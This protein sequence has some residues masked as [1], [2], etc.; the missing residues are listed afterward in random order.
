MIVNKV[1]I[2][3]IKIIYKMSTDP[4]YLFFVS[5]RGISCHLKSI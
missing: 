5:F 2:S 3:D 1:C 4:S